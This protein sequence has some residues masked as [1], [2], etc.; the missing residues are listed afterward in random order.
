MN[1]RKVKWLVIRSYKP[2][3][4]YYSNHLE[5]MCKVLNRNLPQYERFLCIWDF[6]S[7]ITE[8][9]MKIFCDIYHL[10][11]LVNIPTC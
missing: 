4:N 7:G 11:N 8:F 5:S 6:N 3:K 1:L 10:K 9:A 2:H